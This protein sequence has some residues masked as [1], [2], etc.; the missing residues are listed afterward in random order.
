M[1]VIERDTKRKSVG[2]RGGGEEGLGGEI[3][4][5]NCAEQRRVWKKDEKEID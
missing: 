4:G 1:C 2:E 5:L 3:H